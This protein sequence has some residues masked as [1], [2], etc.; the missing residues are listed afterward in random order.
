MALP[1]RSAAGSTLARLR[2]SARLAS[3]RLKWGAGSREAIG[4][5]DRSVARLTIR[6]WDRRLRPLRY[7]H[8]YEHALRE[9]WLLLKFVKLYSRG[10]GYR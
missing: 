4:P 8:F 9:K 10:G 7:K 1:L 5:S 6:T 3:G 2:C